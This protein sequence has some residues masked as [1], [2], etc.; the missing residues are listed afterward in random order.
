MLSKMH[1]GSCHIFL[2]NVINPVD[3][4]QPWGKHFCDPCN[5]ICMEIAMND[6]FNSY[7][8]YALQKSKIYSSK[9]S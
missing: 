6:A 8:A 9:L 4:Y 2:E 3:I 7:T 5:L 1:N